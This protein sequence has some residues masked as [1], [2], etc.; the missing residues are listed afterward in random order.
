MGDYYPSLQELRQLSQETKNNL[1]SVQDFQQIRKGFLKR[2]DGFDVDETLDM[3]EE[4]NKDGSQDGL[5]S[6]LKSVSDLSQRLYDE[7]SANPNSI[8]NWFPQIIKANKKS[9]SPFKIP[10]TKIWKLPI[11]VAQFLRIEYQ[12]TTKASRKLLNEMI[13]K[14]FELDDD[15]EYFIKTGTFSSKF[16]F[17]NA[18]IVKGEAKEIGEYFQVINNFAMTVGAAH[19]VEICVRE[20]IHDVENN[21][22][23]YSGMPL[24]TEFRAFVDFDTNKIIGIV[25]YWNPLV[26][27]RA[28]SSEL[29]PSTIQKDYTTYCGH[30][31]KLIND[32]NES[33]NEVNNKLN[34]LLPNVD[35]KGRYSVDIMKNGKDLY[36]IDMATME[37]SALTEFL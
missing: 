36:L 18:H 34:F 22:T 8:G 3:L 19:S 6:R 20:Y 17:R 24:R 37:T 15:K 29:A 27:K 4:I 2:T 14:Y 11:E 25:P 28:F 7:F 30:E 35:L 12:D 1:P 16:E 26:M 33:L 5:V 23:I 21:P 32:F 9:N 31:D 10:E 13:F